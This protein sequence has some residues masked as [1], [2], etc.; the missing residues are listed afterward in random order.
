METRILLGGG[1][2]AVNERLVLQRFASWIGPTG[3]VLYLPIATPD[4]GR[5]Q[6]DWI[7]DTLCPLGISKIEMWTDLRRHHPDE[8]A[9]YNGVFI[10]GGNTYY[11]LHQLRTA[12]F[13]QAIREFAEGGGVL[14]GGSAG[15]IVFGR[16]IN[17]CAH[18]DDD[19]AGL[20][21]TTGLDLAHGHA[22]WCHY[23]PNVE[24]LVRS[25]VKHTQI[26]T[27]ALPETTGLWIQ[28]LGQLIP[29]GFDPVLRFTPSSEQSCVS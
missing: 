15:A 3:S 18:M 22:I 28:A 1:G 27:I 24:P 17:T 9:R 26:P 2:S 6:F 23:E 5:A 11:L 13:T 7:S 16:D 21:N 29:L 19:I 25:Y 20:T 8:L 12:D 14:Y 10:G 4:A